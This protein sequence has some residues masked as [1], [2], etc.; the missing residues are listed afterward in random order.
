MVANLKALLALYIEILH[1]F[2][3]VLLLSLLL[4]LY[5]RLLSQSKKRLAPKVQKNI[6]IRLNPY[7]Y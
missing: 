5:F 3:H 6:I 4:Q 7:H 2:V 1:F